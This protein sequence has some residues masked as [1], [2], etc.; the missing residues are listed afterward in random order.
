MLPLLLAAIPLPVGSAV[1]FQ[2]PAEIRQGLPQGFGEQ[3]QVE[4]FD[5][6]ARA[7]V[8]ARELPRQWSGTYQSFAAAAPLTVQ[9]TLESLAPMGQM[10]D[11]RGTLTIG[12]TSMPVQGNLNAKSDQLDLLLLGDNAEAGLENGGEFRGLQGFSLSGWRAPRFT[13]PGGQ[14]MLSAIA[15]S[16]AEQGSGAA[17]EPA[18]I[19]VRGLW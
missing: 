10:V 2:E 14:L 11:V 12:G 16:A 3:V 4:T 18:G 13:I 15:S 5:P 8:L 9:L 19:P 17:A 1:P 6:V 7:T